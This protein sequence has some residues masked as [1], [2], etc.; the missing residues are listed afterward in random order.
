M[1]NQRKNHRK[2]AGNSTFFYVKESAELMTFLLNKFDGM[3]R[4]R[5][6]K[7]LTLG[8]IFV[9]GQRTTQYDYLLRPGMD[10]EVRRQ[11]EKD[12]FRN[13]WVKVVYED[14]YLMVINKKNGL[15]SASAKPQDETAQKVLNKY[16]FQSHQKCTAHTV[17]RLDKET[18]GLMIFAKD[19]KTAIKFEENWKETVY[20]RRYIALVEGAMTDKEGTITSWLKENRMYEVLSSP[21]DN[22]G[23]YAVTHYRTI[24]SNEAYS[25]VELRLETGR[26]NQ[27]RVHMK[28]IKHPVVGDLKYGS[29][30]DPIG[31]VA[32]H[33]YK[34]CFKHPITKEDLQ[35][36][37]DIPV[38]FNKMFDTTK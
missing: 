35:F 2:A 19:R 25:L 37:A 13:E 28:D 16:L 34:L 38:A 15:L 7:L 18:S 22:G 8:M 20:D 26:K 24:K 3:S 36:D 4:S 21:I 14:R 23:K 31:R 12:K 17:H 11:A 6:K 5:V 1:K 29:G 10:V 9:N 32:L 30:N 33:A 27:I